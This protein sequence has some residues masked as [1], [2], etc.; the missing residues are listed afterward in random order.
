[1]VQTKSY[2]QCCCVSAGIALS[3]L[4]CTNAKR[5]GKRQIILGDGYF[6]ILRSNSCRKNGVN[7]CQISSFWVK[8][9]EGRGNCVFLQPESAILIFSANT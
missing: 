9:V 1:M 3:S 7:R 8:K 5:R 2:M 6:I 4:K